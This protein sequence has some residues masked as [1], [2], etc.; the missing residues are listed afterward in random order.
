[1]IKE[2]DLDGDNRVSFSGK[3]LP[4]KSFLTIID[5]LAQG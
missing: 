5:N 1:M 2:A 4:F 3:L